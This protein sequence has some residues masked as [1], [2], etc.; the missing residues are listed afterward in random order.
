MAKVSSCPAYCWQK[1]NCVDGIT[2]VI[3]E[4]YCL[5]KKGPYF[6]HLKDNDDIDLEVVMTLIFHTDSGT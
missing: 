4:F 1:T 2:L 3:E 6:S 5:I